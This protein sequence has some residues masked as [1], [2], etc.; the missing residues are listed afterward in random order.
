M[1]SLYKHAARAFSLAAITMSVA[2]VSMA[3]DEP[4]EY[5]ATTL[6]PTV[7]MI[8]GKGG[9]IAVSAG[10]DGVFIIDDQYQPDVDQLLAAIGK[11]SDQP[12]RFVINTHYHGDHVGGNEAIGKSGAV[13]IAHENIRLRM[14]RDEFNNFWNKTTPAWPDGSLPIVT[15][16]DKVT[17]HFNGEPV[18]VTH[19]P[20]GHTDGDAIVFFPVSNVL[21]MGDIY[22]NGLYPFIDLDGGGSIQGMIAAV[23]LGMEIANDETRV[24]PGHGPM[25]DRQGL[26]VYHAFLTKARDN[27]QAMI[28]QGMDLQQVIAAKP[29]AAWD[30]ALGKVWITP[31]QLA[32][33]IY[34]SLTNVDHFT[35]LEAK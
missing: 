25:S 8:K 9:N 26:A 2:T 21:H 19:V 34:N 3:Q 18:T 35:V 31:E 29:T 23:E 30:E 32:I 5:I 33:F 28:D 7:T 16:N 24:I 22:F 13:I 6:S 12:I 1:R 27:V 11:I 10:E 14:S 4:V 15:F 17:L 20:H